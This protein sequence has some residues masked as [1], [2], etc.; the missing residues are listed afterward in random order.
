VSKVAEAVEGLSGPT[1]NGRE[2]AASGGRAPGGRF[3][4]GNPGGPGRP[5]GARHAALA[6]LDAIGA[7]A[8]EE[9]LRRVVED[10]KAGDLRAAEILLRR[11]WPERKG[12]PVEVALPEVASA[13]NLVAALAAVASA[14]G[15]GELTSEEARAMC[16][17]LESQR[18]A[19]ETAEL[20]AR[21]AALEG[22]V[23]GAAG[24][25]R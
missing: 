20:E 17:V 4:P 14:M 7:E 5:K 24:P 23:P 12:R 1:R 19:I 22:C 8:A 18:R 21:V 6:A 15:R 9:V 25:A 13:A 11:L 16:A 3:A 10:A 2:T